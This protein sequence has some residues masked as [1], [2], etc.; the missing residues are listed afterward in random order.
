MFKPVGDVYSNVLKHTN[1]MLQ[2]P[3]GAV[4]KLEENEQT[5][6]LDAV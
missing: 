3:G 6:F 4:E 1:S 2:Q 5:S